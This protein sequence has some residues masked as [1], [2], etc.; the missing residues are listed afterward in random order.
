MRTVEGGGRKF[1]AQNELTGRKR[2][3]PVR[4]NQPEFNP[5]GII[6][7]LTDDGNNGGRQPAAVSPNE[8]NLRTSLHSSLTSRFSAT[9]KNPAA[10]SRF[11]LSCPE[12]SPGQCSSVSGL[13][14]RGQRPFHTPGPR[15]LTKSRVI[16]RETD[17][18]HS[19]AK[20]RQKEP[21]DLS[22]AR[23][24]GRDAAGSQAGRATAANRPRPRTLSERK[25]LA[26]PGSSPNDGFTEAGDL[27]SGRPAVNDN[28]P[29]SIRKARRSRKTANL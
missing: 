1:A 10:M 7:T 14:A 15:D 25:S 21:P 23:A 8:I 19:A 20:R 5:Q 17:R 22:R 3:G 4:I 11:V 26:G 9:L 16:R 18:R 27:H 29:P 28:Q 13:E 12:F 24:R 2:V 6:A